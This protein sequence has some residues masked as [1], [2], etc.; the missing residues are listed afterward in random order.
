MSEHK[1]SKFILAFQLPGWKWDNNAQ[2]LQ[3]ERIA[4]GYT[5]LRIT[6]Q[7][8][9]DLQELRKNV[10][11]LHRKEGGYYPSLSMDDLLTRIATGNLGLSSSFV[12]AKPAAAAKPAKKLRRKVRP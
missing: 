2:Q 7:T 8:L 6:K 9:A 5:S 1:P 12:A 3:R 11:E 4:S 10:A